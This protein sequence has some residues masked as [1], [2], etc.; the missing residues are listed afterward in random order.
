MLARGLQR[1]RPTDRSEQ[2]RAQNTRKYWR[3][4]IASGKKLQAATPTVVGFPDAV[5]KCLK[6]G[7][8]TS[9][10]LRIQPCMEASGI[11]D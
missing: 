3:E 8:Q 2:I 11:P 10:S 4:E 9:L 7:E 6:Y 1:G 5:L